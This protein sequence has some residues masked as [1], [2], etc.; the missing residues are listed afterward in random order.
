[1]KTIKVVGVSGSGKSTLIS[2]LKK[3]DRRINSV[4]YGEI[5][6]RASGLPR[7]KLRFTKCQYYKL[8]N[9]KLRAFLR[10]YRNSDCLI[11]FDEHI[12]IETCKNY[13]LFLRELYRSENTIGIIFLDTAAEEVVKRRPSSSLEKIQADQ[14][15]IK[16]R[17]Q[18]LTEQ[19]NI[20]RLI[21]KASNLEKSV[22]CAFYFIQKIMGR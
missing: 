7:E 20:P 15:I 22:N 12:E 5:L 4:N 8:A 16:N 6:Q 9:Q 11:L 1:M 3:L 17:V 13:L 18:Y 19:L 2:E 14:Q 21:I 10:R